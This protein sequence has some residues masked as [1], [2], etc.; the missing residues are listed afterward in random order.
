[1]KKVIYSLKL[2]LIMM[3]LWITK[4]DVSAAE[5][6]GTRTSKDYTYTLYDDGLL[7]MSRAETPNEEGLS[8]EYW[9]DTYTI[10]RIEIEPGVESIGS[11]LFSRFNNLTEVVIPNT[12][13]SIGDNAFSNCSSLVTVS[14]PN[15][16][17][18]IG[19]GAFSFC[20]NLTTLSLPTTTL[21]IGKR[22]FTQCEKLDNVTIP[23]ASSLGGGVFGYCSNLFNVIISDA[24]LQKIDADGN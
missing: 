7:K 23:D 4:M 12:V 1:M 17:T 18:S 6:I 21:S 14:I 3:M 15:T 19:E 10:S 9:N 8:L 11:G 20:G 5:V 22:A 2:I 24:K 13:V 16:V